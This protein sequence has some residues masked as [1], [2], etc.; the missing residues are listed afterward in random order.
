LRGDALPDSIEAMDLL[1][2]LLPSLPAPTAAVRPRRAWLLL[3]L[4][5]GLAA[6]GRKP[7]TLAVPPPE[8]PEKTPP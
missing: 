8:Q 1:R 3:A 7:E 4:A 6:C 5:A 2:R